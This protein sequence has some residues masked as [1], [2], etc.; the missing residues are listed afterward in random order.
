MLNKWD[1]VWDLHE[2]QCPCD[3]Q[4]VEFLETQRISGASIFHFGTG[5]HHYVGIRNAENGSN[6]AVLGITCSRGEYDAY[7]DLA[8]EQPRISRSYKAIFGDIYILDE[9]LLPSFDVVT[10]FHLCEFRTEENSAYSAMTDLQVARLLIEKLRSGGWVLFY[11]GS[12]AFDA[13]QPVITEIEE[14]GL[15]ERVGTYKTLLL[16]RKANSTENVAAMP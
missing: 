10:L 9:R 1:A 8:I 12:Q 14:S 7:M 15:I 13:A 4:F 6:N 5:R 11:T 2:D 16:Y 3:V